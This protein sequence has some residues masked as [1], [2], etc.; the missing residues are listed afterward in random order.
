MLRLAGRNVLRQKG[1]TATTLAAIAFGVASIVLAKGFVEDTF[2]QL[3][4]AIVHSQSG[5]IQLAR[6]GFFEHGAHQPERYLVEDPEG[7]KKR[8]MKIPEV[9]DAMAR[10][11]FSGLL[12]NGRADLSVIGEGIEPEKEA[13]LGTF[14]RI[15]TGRRL[16]DSDQFGALV[17]A[18]VAKSL[19]LS[20]GDSVVLV[21]STSDGA[22]NSLDLNVVGVFQSFSKEYDNRAIKIPLSAAQQLLNT[23]GA[24]TLVVTLHETKKT[25][26]VARLLRER[27][28]WRDQTV[29]TWQDLNDFY[30]KT[31]DMYRIQFGGLQAIIL[32]MVLLG[33]VNSVNTTV[34]ERTSEFGTMRALGNRGK[35]VFGIIV[36]ESVI[37]GVAGSTVGILFALGVSYL[38]SIVGIPMPP[39]PNSDLSYVA[40]VRLSWP[41]V[42][43][44]FALGVATTTI[45]SLV[46]GIRLARIDIS[47]ALRSGV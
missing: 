5:H 25:A 19:R 40:F 12:N 41:P 37:L 22:M 8:I 21:M 13:R 7:D 10:L 23:K 43:L 30:P 44:A 24:N 2:V 31:V 29:K 35:T 14:L 28:V 20:P 45:A 42:L 16:A 34:F 1:R 6:E 15:V 17:G 4:E 38:V 26:D 27:T 39:P 9:S 36:L 18:G 33:V 47:R 11:S 3:G 32:L 46:P